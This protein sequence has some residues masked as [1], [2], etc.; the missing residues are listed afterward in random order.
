MRILD[1][2]ARRHGRPEAAVAAS[3]P[4]TRTVIGERLARA[5]GA[6]SAPSENGRLRAAAV[7][8]VLCEHEGELGV[9]LTMRARKMSRHASQFALPGGLLNPDETHGDGA[10]RELVEEL[11]LELGR[12]SIAGCL[13]DYD[14][15][16]GFRLRPIVLW[17]GELGSLRPAPDEVAEVFHVPLA[18]LADPA[19]PILR[20][21][22]GLEKPVIQLPLG[23]QLIHAPT[24]AILYQFAQAAVAG[25]YV[26]AAQFEEPRFAWK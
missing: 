20:Q 9:L 6:P 25:R 12:D 17:V 10:L 14:T 3:R 5:F 8:I 15:R 22:E 19:V 18:A 24:G 2:T 1:S 23:D 21:V 13:P 16:S 11:G 26:N 7:A 4:V